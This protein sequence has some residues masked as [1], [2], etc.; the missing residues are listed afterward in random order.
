M[1]RLK[2]LTIERRL[3]RSGWYHRPLPCRKKV[4][5]PLSL[6]I[7]GGPVLRVLHHS[8]DG[9][10]VIDR[11]PIAKVSADG[12]PPVKIPFHK[13]LIHNGNIGGVAAIAVGKSTPGNEFGS[14][15]RE[16][17]R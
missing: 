4:H 12:I 11:L 17:V 3:F 13:G 15:R 1:G 2:K 10:E 8:H 16:I 14:D 9:E 5:R 6:L 7:I